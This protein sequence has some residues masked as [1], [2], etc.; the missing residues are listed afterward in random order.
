M[1]V[2]VFYKSL[3]GNTGLLAREI[4]KALEGHQVIY[5]EKA[6]ECPKADLYLVGSWTD[7]GT[8]CQE[9]AEFLK[10]LENQKI[11]WFG[12]AG[13]GG[14]QE[15]YNNLFERVKE[16][17]PASNQL[18]GSFYC[19]G[20]MPE[21]VRNRYAAML[22]EHPEDKKLQASIEN[23]DRAKSHPDETDLENFRSWVR[24]MAEK[25]KEC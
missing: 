25:V 18:L 7:K 24:Q 23:F 13:F 15:Y 19:Q 22:K 12:T 6:E 5:C 10:G 4:E 21:A 2:A 11:A 8:C 3:T 9:V 17:I 1:K 16:G 14:S 20:K